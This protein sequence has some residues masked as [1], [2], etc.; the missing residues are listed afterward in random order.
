MPQRAIQPLQTCEHN[1]SFTR[2][3]RLHFPD[4]DNIFAT[5]HAKLWGEDER[6]ARQS[7]T[8]SSKSECV[9]RIASP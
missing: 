3:F 7:G 1:M 6:D 5:L 2:C 4:P 8:Q 9:P